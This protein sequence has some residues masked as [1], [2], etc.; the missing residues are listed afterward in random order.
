M[1]PPAI[2]NKT[3]A[4][5]L[6]GGKTLNKAVNPDEAVAYG[7]A[8][9]AAILNGDK[10]NIVRDLVLIDV[11]PL[12]LGIGSG[13]YFD[14]MSVVIKRNTPI[15]AR[16]TDVFYALDDYQT[17]IRFPVYEGEYPETMYNHLLGE[18]ILEGIPCAP[19]GEVQVDVTF[20]IDSDGILN[21]TAV[22]R[23]TGNFNQISIRRDDG[24]LTQE[25]IDYMVQDAERCLETMML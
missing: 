24:H 20:E 7:A 13:R 17:E 4:R 11:T 6:F 2:H 18:F 19:A 12:S 1:R 5:G 8:V 23:S 25:A 3:D 9:Q 14:H 21:V 15:P 10:S 16:I 22:E